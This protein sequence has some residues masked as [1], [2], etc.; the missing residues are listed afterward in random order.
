MAKATLSLPPPTSPVK[1]G[2]KVLVAFT[3]A[4]HGTLRALAVKRGEPTASLARRL[5]LAAL[6]AL[7]ST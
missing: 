7:G 1:R 3:A 2:R 6:D 4:E 5:I